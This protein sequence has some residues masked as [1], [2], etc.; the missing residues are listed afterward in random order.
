MGRS[1]FGKYEQNLSTF[2]DILVLEPLSWHRSFEGNITFD[3]HHMCIWAKFGPVEAFM[4]LLYQEM[5][6]KH[7]RSARSM[8]KVGP[9]I[10]VD[11]VRSEGLR[12]CEE[13][14]KARLCPLA[15]SHGSDSFCTNKS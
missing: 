12:E 1:V 7:C 8:A 13:Y 3:D 9:C 2:L 6:A 15:R 10:S 4:N 14:G 5:W 11:E